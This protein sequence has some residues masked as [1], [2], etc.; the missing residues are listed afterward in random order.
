MRGEAGGGGAGRGE[1]HAVAGRHDEKAG[2]YR[3]GVAAVHGQEADPQ[4]PGHDQAGTG[5]EEGSR[6]EPVQSAKPQVLEVKPSNLDV[7]W[8]AHICFRRHL[9]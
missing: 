5:D 9:H 7:V 3:A 4:H 6:A 2:Q 1:G 8:T